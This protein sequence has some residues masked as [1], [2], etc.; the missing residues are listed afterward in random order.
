MMIDADIRDVSDTAL[1][2]AAYRAQESLSPNAAFHDPL[3]D[4]LVGERGRALR[5]SMP[6]SDIMQWIMTLR[7]VAIDRMIL[8]AIARGADTV[9]N[10]GAGLDTRPY[11]LSLPRNLRWIEIDFPNIIELKNARLQS[12]APGCEL[13]RMSLDVTNRELKNQVF[14]EIAARSRSVAIL[15]EGLLPYL[16]P[17]EVA[18]LADD[19]RGIANIHYWIQD[20]YNGSTMPAAWRKR[21]KAAPFRFIESDWLGFFTARAWNVMEQTTLIDEARRLARPP[22]LAW[23]RL[24]LFALTPPAIRQEMQGSAG[25]VMFGP[26]ARGASPL[27]AGTALR[28]SSG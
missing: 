5:R 22:P 6:G 28:R 7:T 10:M 15:T 19:L 16:E 13:E 2:V 26:T 17:A 8:S 3:A 24:L 25:Y 21:L 9:V 1:W 27:V 18:T 20:Y 12:H 11:R 14:A 4:L 23:W